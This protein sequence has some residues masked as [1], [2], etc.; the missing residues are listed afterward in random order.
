[1]R[2]KKK[3]KWGKR[4]KTARGKKKAALLPVWEEQ[5]SVF[6]IR[7]GKKVQHSFLLREC[8]RSELKECSVIIPAREFIMHKIARFLF[9]KSAQIRV[10]VEDN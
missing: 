8:R 9:S 1:M 2:K 7:G 3:Q 10:H 5:P 4:E 6:D